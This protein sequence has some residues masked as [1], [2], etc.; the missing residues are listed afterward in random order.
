[1]NEQTRQVVEIAGVKLDLDMRTSTRVETLRVGDRVKV[2]EKSY[3]DWKAHPGVVVGFEPFKS[4]PT[5]I[6]AVARVT[7][8]SVEIGFV[9]LNAKS[10]NVEIVK[11]IDDDDTAL[12]KD[13]VEAYFIDQIAKK[14][15]EI[16]ELERRREFFLREFRAYWKPV[17]T[18]GEVPA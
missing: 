3:S 6:V 9:Y 7:Y 13:K 12:A 11:S 14:N 2:L 18:A 10:E 1:M 8:T 4:L 15:A 17:E 16:E 5:I